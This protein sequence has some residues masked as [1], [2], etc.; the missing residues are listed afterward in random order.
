MIRPTT[1]GVGDVSKIV[2]ADP[3]GGTGPMSIEYKDDG[4]PDLAV[5]PA[6]SA[7]GRRIRELINLK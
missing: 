1:M 2:F 4:S 6:T 3:D 7:S 5:M